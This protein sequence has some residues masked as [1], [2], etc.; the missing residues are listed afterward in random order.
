LSRR[1]IEN[2]KNLM[3]LRKGDFSLITRH[4]APVAANRLLTPR[5][6]NADLHG[7]FMFCLTVLQQG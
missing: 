6:F 4:A 7:V 1:K 5:T 3:V 2:F